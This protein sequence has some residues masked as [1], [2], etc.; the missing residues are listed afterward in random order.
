MAKEAKVLIGR[1]AG[2]KGIKGDVRIQSYTEAPKDVAAYGPV[3]DETGTRTFKVRVVGEAK[4]QVI[5]RLSGI[6]DR[7]AAEALK[8]MALY[9]AKSALPAPAPGEY[10]EA[11]LIG[12]EARTKDGAPFGKVVQVHDYGAGPSL[13]IAPVGGGAPVLVPFTA[14]AVPTVDIAAGRVE[15][16]PPEGLLGPPERPGNEDDGR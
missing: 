3:T 9:V 15:I 11:D 8:G 12:L 4:G 1:I 14:Q 2:P 16:D 13:E 10:Y 7:T 5:A 6:E